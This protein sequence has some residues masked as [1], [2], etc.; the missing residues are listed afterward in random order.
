MATILFLINSILEIVC[1]QIMHNKAKFVCYFFLI[2]KQP[3]NQAL[4]KK[5]LKVLLRAGKT[6]A[7]LQPPLNC[8]S[9]QLQAAFSHRNFLQGA[10]LFCVAGTLNGCSIYVL[11]TMNSKS[12]LFID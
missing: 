10:F 8:F 1:R 2:K 9:D 7:A 12:A 6:E 11:S 4:C 3:K 5:L